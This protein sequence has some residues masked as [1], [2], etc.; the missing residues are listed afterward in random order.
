MPLTIVVN[1]PGRPPT[2]AQ[3]SSASAAIQ[4]ISKAMA[5]HSDARLEQQTLLRQVE[6]VYNHGEFVPPGSRPGTRWG[7]DSI[8]EFR[9]HLFAWPHEPQS[10][11]RIDHFSDKASIWRMLC[12]MLAGMTNVSDA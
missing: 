6:M 5:I 11:Q 1:P 9:G 12:G 3:R 4:D 10:V 7:A 8:C 2:L